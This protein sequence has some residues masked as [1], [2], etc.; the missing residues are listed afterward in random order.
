MYLEGSG[1]FTIYSDHTPLSFIESA[2]NKNTKLQRWATKISSFRGQIVYIKGKDNV[3]TDF[4]SRLEEKDIPIPSVDID[5]D[6]SI[7][8]INTDRLSD[9]DSGDDVPNIDQ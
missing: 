9:A 7:D 2:V 1:N 5:I 6:D 8:V 4:L 3:K